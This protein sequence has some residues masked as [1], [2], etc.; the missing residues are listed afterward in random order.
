MVVGRPAEIVQNAEL[1]RALAPLL[2]ASRLDA[3]AKASGVDLRTLPEAL[4]AGFDFSTLYLA[5]TPDTAAVRRRFEARLVSGLAVAE[6]HPLVRVVTGVVG[7]TPEALV[8]VAPM[9]TVCRDH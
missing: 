2:P 1:S 3:Y 9:S 8:T 6:P 7:R 4:I 5:K